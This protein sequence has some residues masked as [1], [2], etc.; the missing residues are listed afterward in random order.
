MS[1]KCF[2]NENYSI[3][4]CSEALKNYH[5]FYLA[6]HTT[7]QTEEQN[8]QQQAQMQQNVQAQQ[9]ATTTANLTSTPRVTYD[10]TPNSIS[11]GSNNDHLIQKKT[12]LTEKEKIVFRCPDCS[13]SF[14]HAS[15]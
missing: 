7:F 1:L 11:N 10:Q 6:P 14:K 8:Q 13:K 9:Q 4:S 5:N 2:G 12:T 3:N 15:G